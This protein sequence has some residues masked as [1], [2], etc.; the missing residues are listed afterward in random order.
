TTLP[1]A[2]VPHASEVRPLYV[3][4]GSLRHVES[5]LAAHIGPF[6]EY[7]VR[8][9]ANAASDIDALLDQLGKHIDSGTQ[10]QQFFSRCRQWLHA[11]GSAPVAQ[12][13]ARTTTEAPS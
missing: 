6:A 9:A 8:H 4:A 13:A 7:A 3:E 2:P 11:A 1:P 12:A 5:E 10:R